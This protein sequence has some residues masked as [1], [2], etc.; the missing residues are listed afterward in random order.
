MADGR[1]SGGGGK[2]RRSSVQ[3]STRTPLTHSVTLSDDLLFFSF[4]TL[5]NHLN[6]MH[7]N[8]T[9]I[10]F[11]ILLFYAKMYAFVR[12]PNSF[13][14]MNREKTDQKTCY[15]SWEDP[16]IIAFLV[17]QPMLSLCMYYPVRPVVVATV[18]W[19][20][21]TLVEEDSHSE[22]TQLV[23]DAHEKFNKLLLICEN[24]YIE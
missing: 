24:K 7:R 12:T 6:T 9:A 20:P 14:L 13:K 23:G 15:L 5:A 1:D 4:K 21:S 10:K 19:Q 8:N 3:Y 16:L 22:K 2:G 11:G 18:A 17:L